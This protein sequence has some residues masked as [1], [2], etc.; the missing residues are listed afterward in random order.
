M[1]LDTKKLFSHLTSFIPQSKIDELGQPIFNYSAYFDTRLSSL[2][3]W[4]T[5]YHPP[6]KEILSS[7]K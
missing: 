3:F 1:I 7:P 2:N 4:Y 5:K 6:L